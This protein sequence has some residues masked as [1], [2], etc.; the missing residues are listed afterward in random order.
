MGINW[1]NEKLIDWQSKN[2]NC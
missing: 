2:Y 1:K